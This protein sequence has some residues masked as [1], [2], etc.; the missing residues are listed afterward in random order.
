[1]MTIRILC[2]DGKKI[3]LLFYIIIAILNMAVLLLQFLI[4]NSMMYGIWFEITHLYGVRERL[5]VCVYLYVKIYKC[6]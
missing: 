3:Q 5:C 6:Y 4:I 1:M 2:A